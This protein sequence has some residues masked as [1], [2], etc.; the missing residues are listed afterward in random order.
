MARAE[1]APENGGKTVSMRE[2]GGGQSVD[3]KL[4]LTI[5]YL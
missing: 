4:L 1:A 3:V 5:I 2:G